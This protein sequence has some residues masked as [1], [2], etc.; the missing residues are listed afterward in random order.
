MYIRTFV[1]FCESECEFPSI[2]FCMIDD[3]S[4][5]DDNS[6]NRRRRNSGGNARKFGR[7]EVKNFFSIMNL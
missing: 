1:K 3:R 6:S 2:L 5:V 4:R 7:E